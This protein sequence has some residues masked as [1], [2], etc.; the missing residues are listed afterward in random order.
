MSRQDVRFGVIAQAVLFVLGLQMQQDGRAGYVALRRRQLV[1]VT[2]RLPAGGGRLPGL[3]GDECDA[4]GHHEARIEAHTEL[5]DELGRDLAFLFADGL[6][7]LARAR[8]RDGPDVLHHLLAR[9]ADAVIPHAER[10]RG[11]IRLEAN[12]QLTGGRQLWTG[13]GLEAHFVEGVRGV[14]DQ[15]PQEDVLMGVKGMDHEVQ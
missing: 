11:S 10:A 1:A 4:V 6:E 2:A 9:H 15:L 7:E 3:A 8:A 5:A 12:L 13:D 14:G